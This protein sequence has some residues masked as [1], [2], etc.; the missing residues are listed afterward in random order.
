MGSE[1][2]IYPLRSFGSP[3]RPTL[4]AQLPTPSERYMRRRNC[5]K[6]GS[7]ARAC[8]GR[9]LRADRQRKG[10]APS[11]RCAQRERHMPHVAT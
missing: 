5:N 3:H 2:K 9:Q 10:A 8:T 4:W 6:E 11:Q 1:E 7:E